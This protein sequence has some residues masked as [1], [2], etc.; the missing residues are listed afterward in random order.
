LKI[1]TDKTIDSSEI[2]KYSEFLSNQL[3]IQ[4]EKNETAEVKIFSAE[5]KEL[6]ATKY[7]AEYINTH[8]NIAFQTKGEKIETE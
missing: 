2:E 5:G 7:L 8:I 3:I 1:L 4:L 6:F